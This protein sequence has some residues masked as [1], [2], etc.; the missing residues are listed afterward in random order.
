VRL[1]KRV[2]EAQR[3]ALD[4]VKVGHL[5]PNEPES[6]AER[7]ATAD[8]QE[9]VARVIGG[10]HTRQGKAYA[11][12]PMDWPGGSLIT[13]NVCLGDTWVPYGALITVM[14]WF[15]KAPVVHIYDRATIVREVGEAGFVDVEE[16]DVG[17]QGT[18]AFIVARKPGGS[19]T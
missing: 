8:R 7:A 10:E 1:R 16:K 5:H 19:S 9:Q 4:E 12:R 6:P 18:V 14:R 13:S 3:K 15:G 2:L 11:P 17:A